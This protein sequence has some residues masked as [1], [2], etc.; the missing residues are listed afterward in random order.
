MDHVVSK[1]RSLS[2]ILEKLLYQIFFQIMA[3]SWNLALC[4]WSWISHRHKQNFVKYSC[5]KSSGLEL[6]YIMTCGII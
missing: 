2:Q 5:P 3:Q 6:S 1:T 4:C